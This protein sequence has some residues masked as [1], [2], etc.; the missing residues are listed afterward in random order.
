[1]LLSLAC[2]MCHPAWGLPNP[3][4]G[5]QPI[6]PQQWQCQINARLKGSPHY[7]QF[8]G[9]DAW[10]GTGTLKCRTRNGEYAPPRTLDI[11]FKSDF[12]GF[13]AGDLSIVELRILIS[14][15]QA[16]G[17]IQLRGLVDDIDAGPHVRYA[18]TSELSEARVYVLSLTPEMASR[19]LK[20]GTM[21]VRAQ[22]SESL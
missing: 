16:P 10:E 13:G 17:D 9:V 11:S 12:D 15:Y 19:S 6:A 21:F 4:M 3:F 2:L 22:S 5:L 1:M 20:S 7:F 14:T 8:Y 18:M